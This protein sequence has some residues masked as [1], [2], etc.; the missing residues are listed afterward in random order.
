MIQ[1]LH[2]HTN[3]C[4]GKDS[5]EEMVAAALALGVESLGFSGH[6]PLPGEPGNWANM[7]V[8]AYRKEI[9]RL[10][11]KYAGR[12]EILLGI[13]QD[14]D[15]PASQYQWD[16]IIHSVHGIRVGGEIIWMDE[17]PD[18]TE[19][20]VRRHFGGKA[21]A[22]AE[23]Y[24]RRIA[25]KALE[26]ADAEGSFVRI[27]GHLDLLTKYSERQKLFDEE[28]SRYKK[29]AFEA[30]EALSGRGLIFEINTG[31]VAR[32]YRTTPYPSAM[33]LRELARRK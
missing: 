3:F 11:E 28:N 24:Y 2:T 21:E 6:S 9:L 17:S 7:D 18:V 19:S 33:L 31:P 26:Y 4:D 30:I 12:I 15:S 20:A 22:L 8:A 16:Y 27:V 29:A 14:A 1:N 23:A 5:P 25:E 10:R 32:G 13:E